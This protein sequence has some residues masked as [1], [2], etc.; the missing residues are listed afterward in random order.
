MTSTGE[1]AAQVRAACAKGEQARTALEQAKDLA[2]EAHDVLARALEGA[3]HLG[4]D[5]EQVLSA[6]NQVVDG[7]EGHLWPLINEAVKA[8]EDF[9]AELR[10]GR[11][12]TTFPAPTARG[13][14]QPPQQHPARQSDTADP[15][16][17]PPERIERLRRELPPDVPPPDQ[18]PP[19]TPRPKTHGRWIGPD[20][21]ARLVVSGEDEMYRESE[22]VLADLGFRRKL[23]RASDVEMKLAAYMRN[24]G[25]RSAT[26]L[27]N[28]LP[29][30]GPL[31]CDE[32]V[33]VLLPEGCT[34][35]V[36]GANGFTKT[37]RGGAAPPWRKG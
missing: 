14:A 35:T 6:L 4:S 25:V 27:I 12:P 33:P 30:R 15:P 31:G 20:G 3:R 10:G 1:V 34:M 9:A 36:H 21:Q 16:V 18:R 26:L 5:V 37:Y 11:Q 2:G 19:G 17:I 29:C 28:N 32:L 8:A 23:T 13:P 7:C 24:H 22:T